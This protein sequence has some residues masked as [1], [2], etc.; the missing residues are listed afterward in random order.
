MGKKDKTLNK[1]SEKLKKQI[2]KMSFETAMT[3]LEEIVELY[4]HKKLISIQ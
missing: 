3:R 1:M 2:A 4:R